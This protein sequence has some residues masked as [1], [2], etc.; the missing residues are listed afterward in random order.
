MTT[1]RSGPPL[2]VSLTLAATAGF[3][4]I[5]GAIAGSA[6]G[7]EATVVSSPPV[8]RNVLSGPAGGGTPA[9]SPPR[10]GVTPLNPVALSQQPTNAPEAQPATPQRTGE[11]IIVLDAGVPDAKTRGS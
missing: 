11:R 8:T 7:P 1:K 9:V 5:V 4:A 2:A 6:G 3:A 10:A